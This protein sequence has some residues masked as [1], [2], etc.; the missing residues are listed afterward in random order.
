MEEYVRERDEILLPTTK[1]N[2]DADGGGGMT[3]IAT[4]SDLHSQVELFEMASNL[5]WGVWGVL[6]AAGE[7]TD[8]T[9]RMENAESRLEGVFDLD[10]WDNLRYAK[11]RL[12]RYRVWKDGVLRNGSSSIL[13]L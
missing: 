1:S 5:Y 10:T 11:N 9:F 6:Q 12:E 7:V 8:G 2:K 3:M 4:V 13:L